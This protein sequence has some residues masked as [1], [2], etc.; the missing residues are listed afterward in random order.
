MIRAWFKD[1]P[2]YLVYVKARSYFFG[3]LQL[4]KIILFLHRLGIVTQRVVGHL[5]MRH[6]DPAVPLL[7]SAEIQPCIA[8]PMEVS[9]LVS[10][11][12]INTKPL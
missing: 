8:I 12:R 10:L 9:I 3:A 11:D 4:N 6:P 2:S 7:G 5:A 1:F